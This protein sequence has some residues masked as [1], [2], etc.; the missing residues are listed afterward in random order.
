ML[1]ATVSLA[2]NVPLAKHSVLAT[3]ATRPARM[4]R[5][6]FMLPSKG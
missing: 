5:F 2:A 3:A 6:G 4:M 1:P